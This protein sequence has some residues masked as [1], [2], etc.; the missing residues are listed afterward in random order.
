MSRE[1][2]EEACSARDDCSGFT[3]AADKD[4]SWEIQP[5]VCIL[6]NMDCE[7]P[8]TLSNESVP[9]VECEWVNGTVNLTVNETVI[10]DRP[11]KVKRYF[12]ETYNWTGLVNATVTRDVSYNATELES[13]YN[14]A[15]GQY[16]NVTV[17]RTRTRNETAREL[18]NATEERVRVSY[19]LEDVIYPNST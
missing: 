6:A 18:Q 12:N 19:Y 10:Y 17:T 5:Q 7:L 2:C 14:N 1:A 13:V 9:H 3:L 15:T 4:E 16:E 8:E 11:G